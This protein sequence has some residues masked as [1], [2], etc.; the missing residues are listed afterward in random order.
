MP[1]TSKWPEH[2]TDASNDVWTGAHTPIAADQSAEVSRTSRV[3]S[4]PLQV[5]WEMTHDCG[6]KATP[7]RTRKARNQ[8]H[9]STAEAFHL[10]EQVAAMHVPLL[11]LTG[12]DPL[13]R[14][15]LLDRKSTRLNSSHLGISYAV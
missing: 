12:G 9:F 15:D 5:T 8:Q 2:S 6:W 3:H 7:A 13:L 4:R 11:A 1:S 14:P 10:I